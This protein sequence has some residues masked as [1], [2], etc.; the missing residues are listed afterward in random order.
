MGRYVCPHGPVA[1]CTRVGELVS[2]RPTCSGVLFRKTR[3]TSGSKKVPV[4]KKK[5]SSGVQVGG[6]G[7]L[8]EGFGDWGHWADHGRV[9]LWIQ[10]LSG[11]CRKGR[12]PRVKER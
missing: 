3:R 9:R 1:L 2:W 8:G 6:G 4:E 10:G 12:F 11:L 5:E 7:K